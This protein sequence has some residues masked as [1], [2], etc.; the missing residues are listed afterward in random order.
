MRLKCHEQN[1]GHL[2]QPSVN[3]IALR[4]PSALLHM[5]AIV[6]Q[7]PDMA[8]YTLA[9][10]WLKTG[11]VVYIVDGILYVTSRTIKEQFTTE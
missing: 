4:L 1:V 11:F 6:S 9:T 7:K 5:P 3:Q 10:D 2:V 8:L